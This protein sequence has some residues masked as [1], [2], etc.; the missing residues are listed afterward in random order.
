M[1]EVDEAVKL[2]ED[3]I[4]FLE[5][6]GSSDGVIVRI[7]EG[8]EQWFLKA[9]RACD[10]FEDGSA[11]YSKGAKTLGTLVLDA[12]QDLGIRILERED[13]AKSLRE[14]AR[15]ILLGR[16]GEGGG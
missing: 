11:L 3:A 9:V 10:S 16:N 1:M 12:I 5:L 6:Q 4:E 7:E 8:S 15:I 13:E 14:R 2:I